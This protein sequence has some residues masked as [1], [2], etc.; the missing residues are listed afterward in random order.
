MK[1]IWA[2]LKVKI[3]L[4]LSLTV[5]GVANAQTYIQIAPTLECK[6]P[7]G[8]KDFFETELRSIQKYMDSEMIHV[9][10]YSFLP[11]MI[12]ANNGAVL[13]FDS[14][15]QNIIRYD[16]RSGKRVNIAW[17]SK[18]LKDPTAQGKRTL[19]LIDCSEN[20]LLFYNKFK[21]ETVVAH[22][23]ENAICKLPIKTPIAIRFDGTDTLI[24][25][26]HTTNVKS[27]SCRIV[28]VSGK[29]KIAVSESLFVK[30]GTQL[31]YQQLTK[32]K[33]RAI[34]LNYSALKDSLVAFATTMDFSN[35]TLAHVSERF[36]V[37]T[38]DIDRGIGSFLFFDRSNRKLVT[39]VSIA[40]KVLSNNLIEYNDIDVNAPSPNVDDPASYIRVTS[41]KNKVFF[42]FQSKG[43]LYLYSFIIPTT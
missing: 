15:S 2:S 41:I 38:S 30:N 24:I 33:F 16:P 36:Y 11:N 34:D 19:D 37:L 28:E 39:A 3:S 6:F 12:F 7:I 8:E 27:L 13:L 22:M 1:V 32:N 31:F 20:H 40:D 4:L 18:K 21:K 43:V 5:F 14:F 35:F 25:S 26:G 42:M 17:L 9:N 23:G 29:N 10:N